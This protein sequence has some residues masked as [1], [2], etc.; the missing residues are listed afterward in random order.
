MLPP[1][2]SAT[3]A[4][5]SPNACNLCHTE[6]DAEWA[7]RWVREWYGSEYQEPFM[8]RAGLIDA[9]RKRDWK[10]LPEMLAYIIGEDRDEVF[11]TSLIRLL[12]N[13]PD[14]SKWPALITAVGD[15]SPLV[16]AA[17]VTGLAGYSEPEAIR[18]MVSATGDEIRLVRIRAAASLAQQPAAELNPREREQVNRA[19]RE[20]EAYLK[21]GPDQWNS[22]YNLGNYYVNLGRLEDGLRAFNI[23]TRLQPKSIPPLVNASMIYA[24]L[25]DSRS[26]ENKLRSALEVEPGNAIVNFNLGLLLA[27]RGQI[28]E[29]EERLRSA[30]AADPQ[31]ASAAYNLAVLVAARDLNQAVKWCRTAAE[32]RPDEPKYAYT[33]AFYLSQGGDLR[34][35]IE[36]LNTL[37]RNHPEYFEAYAL[38]GNAFLEQGD[39]DEARSVYERALA[40]EGIALGTRR[41]FEAMLARLEP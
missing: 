11:A 2:P 21:C 3:I 26:A 9:G 10:R 1:T 27:E 25:G 13:C 18:A 33:L 15:P 24:R 38:L 39:F 28:E 29:A 8:Y 31:M 7:D 6:E 34:E 17:A 36:L 19:T 35:S 32:L 5:E 14:E 37:I 16:R 30:L 40:R 23:A 12:G 22:H 4:F 41:Q 20:Y